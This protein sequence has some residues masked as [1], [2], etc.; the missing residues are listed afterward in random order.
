MITQQL[1]LQIDELVLHG[2]PA[3]HAPHIR[4]ALERELGRLF[5]AQGVPASLAAS[6]DVGRL[7]GGSF[8]HQPDATPDSIGSQLAQSVFSGL[9][10]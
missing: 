4:A 6:A 1:D 8:T 2:F 3:A 10:A 7:N 9:T 5:L